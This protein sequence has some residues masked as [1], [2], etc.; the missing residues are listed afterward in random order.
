MIIRQA[1][2][3]DVSA[4]AELARQTYAAAFGESFT[5]SDLAAHLQVRLSD[6]YFE[7]AIDEDVFLLAVDGG[8]PIGFLQFGDLQSDAVPTRRGDQELRR[9]YVLAEFQNKGIGTQ[10]ME[11]AFAHP[12]LNRAAQ[13]YLDVWERNHAARRLYERYG[14][15]VI[16]SKTLTTASGVASEPDLVMVRRSQT[17]KPKR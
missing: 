15:E 8:R 9:I 16:G 14:F 10:L 11:R 17:P 5:E 3:A 1:E 12:R 7:R 13:V 4:L 6:S 2:K